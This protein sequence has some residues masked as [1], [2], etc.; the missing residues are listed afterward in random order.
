MPRFLRQIFHI[1]TSRV[2]LIGLLILVQLLWFAAATLYLAQFATWVNVTLTALS[3]LVELYIVAYTGNPSYKILWILFIGAA[4]VLGG[5]IYLFFGNKRPS[6]RM[7]R[8][9][10]RARQRTGTLSIPHVDVS[11]ALPG[12]QTGLSYELEAAGYSLYQ[13]TEVEYYSVGD[14]FFPQYL[15]DLRSANHFIFIEFFIYADGVMWQSVR[16]ILEQKA[17]AGLDVRVAFDDLGSIRCLPKYF[18]R[19]LE[20]AGVHVLRFNPFRPALA[21]VMNNRDHRKITVIDG[22][23]GYTGGLNLA[24][25]YIN[26][27]KRF[28]H[29]KDTAVRLCGEAVYSF[30]KMFLEL[31]NTF[32]KTSDRCEMYAPRICHP[33]PFQS[34]GFVQPYANSPFENETLAQSVYLNLIYQARSYVYIFTPYLAID[35]EMQHALCA[36]ARRGVDVRIVTPGIPD[37][38]V[39]YSLTRSYYEPLLRSGVRIYE[40]TPGFIHAK[41]FLVDD[42]AGVVGTINLDFRSL[43]LHLEDAV[44]MFGNRALQTLKRDYIVTFAQSHQVT[45]NDCK[46]HRHNLL[47]QAVLRTISPLL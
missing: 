8:Q 37:K 1:L 41:S 9:M 11:L 4:P 34:D 19:D 38:R 35:D 20:K 7:R 2:V 46:R 10:Q 29:W 30:T 3:I 21:A 47:W 42:A 36:A 17:A 16:D 45:L 44:L 18:Q 28:G 14:D 25:E 6:Q 26:R 32:Y 12:W 24:D 22:F 39:V 33:D 5:L 15:H 27:K 31:W 43:F 40:Y 23:V 13:N